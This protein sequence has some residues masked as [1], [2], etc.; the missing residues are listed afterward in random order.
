MPVTDKYIHTCMRGCLPS[1]Q[2]SISI[3]ILSYCHTVI[4]IGL[5]SPRISSRL[6]LIITYC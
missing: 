4:H 6:H 3:D 2:Y 5:D 1:Y